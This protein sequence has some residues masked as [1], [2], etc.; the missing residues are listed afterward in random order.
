MLKQK[1][2]LPATKRTETDLDKYFTYLV[3]HVTRTPDVQPIAT[4]SPDQSAQKTWTT[5]QVTILAILATLTLVALW[6]FGTPVLTLLFA[7][8]TILYV[9]LL[10]L[11]AA[12]MIAV[13]RAQPSTP[14]DES[15]I[16]DLAKAPWPAYTI[17]CPLYHE[18]AVVSQFVNAM[19][20]LDY[21]AD[22]LQ[23]LFL[24]EEDDTETRDALRAMT[25]P[26]GYEI[27]TVPQGTPKT[28]P[29]ACNYGL[30]QATGEYVVIFD[31]EDVPD[32]LQLKK[33]VL[34]FAS[35]PVNVACVQAR[36]NFYNSNQSLLCKFFSIE[37]GLW[38]DLILPGLQRLGFSLPLGGTSN[39][40][41][42]AALKALGGWDSYNVTEDCDLG[43]KLAKYNFK[44]I[45]LD[46]TTY[47]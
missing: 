33:A 17:L 29:R 30:Q 18:K 5:P 10:C 43:L 7:L 16:A 36:L 21:P 44:T 47:E 19:K 4:I 20:A 42:I 1:T 12:W 2:P 8:V 38:F 24:T 34:A 14:F 39:H 37:Y 25:L 28:K 3:S 40:F 26:A 31:A 32:P 45:M 13:A 9:A 27:V 6:C 35:N 46:S 15:I 22:C 11:S 23:V 41:R